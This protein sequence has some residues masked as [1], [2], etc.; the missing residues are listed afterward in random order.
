MKVIIAGGTGFLGSYLC[1]HFTRNNDEVIVLTRGVSRIT[2]GVS[3]V[4]WDGKQFGSWCQSMENTD[5]VINLTG[6]SVDCR[7]TEKNKKEIIQSRV[8]AT[9]VLG[10]MISLMEKPPRLWINSST[11][12]IYKYSLDKEMDEDNG[13]IGNDFS[14]RVAKAWEQ[15]FYAYDLPKTRQIT[16]RISLVI[17]ERGG[18]YPVLKKLAKFGLAGKMGSGKQKFAWIHIKDLISIID[19]S[20]TNE[21]ISGPIN[22][23]SPENIT[24]QEFMFELRKSLKVLIGIPQPK[25]LLKLGAILLGTE[26]ELILKSRFVKPKRLL[27]NE[28]SFQFSNIKSALKEITT[29]SN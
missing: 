27:E 14:M 10:E 17:G 11:A 7:Y 24:N 6:K 23:T 8:D 22:C 5:V 26:S 12:T 13:E 16:A 2:N 21:K 28:F 19:F 25:F 29:K 4:N 18:V 3:Y 20:I 9:R 1:E 15:S